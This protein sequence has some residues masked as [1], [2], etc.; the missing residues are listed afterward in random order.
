VIV[1]SS[2]LVAIIR[3]ERDFE[4]YV[5]ALEKSALS[6]MA[7]P[8]Y[9]ELCMVVVANR[10]AQSKQ[11]V[12]YLCRKFRISIIDFTTE[13]SEIAFAAFI[14]YGKGRGHP[15]QLNFGDCISYATSKSELMPLLFKG[16]DFRLT[17]IECA[18]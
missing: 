2:A 17:D 4:I 12:D 16:N 5:D 18:V 1:D 15:A 11:I 8:T 10:D 14:Q 9:L 7:S 13:I 6:K 3:A